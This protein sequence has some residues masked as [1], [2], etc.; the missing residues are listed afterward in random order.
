MNMIDW[1][2][3]EKTET[4]AAG[5]QPVKGYSG[6]AHQTMSGR[7]VTKGVSPSR[8]SS[9]DRPVMPQKTHLKNSG[10]VPQTC[11]QRTGCGTAPTNG[12]ESEHVNY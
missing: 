1:T 12:K 2:I 7:G 9:D 6:Q 10:V 4:G 8:P 5:E 11:V 3:P